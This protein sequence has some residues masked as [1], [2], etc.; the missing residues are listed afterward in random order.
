VEPNSHYRSPTYRELNV[1]DGVGWSNAQPNLRRFDRTSI[2]AESKI[3]P[4][5]N[6]PIGQSK[7]PNEGFM[8]TENGLGIST[9]PQ[10]SV[11]QDGFLK[12][13]VA[14]VG[15]HYT[16]TGQ[17]GIPQTSVGQINVAPTSFDQASPTE[18][19]FSQVNIGQFAVHH[20]GTT[21]VSVTQVAPQN[22]DAVQGSSHQINTT[23]VNILQNSTQTNTSKISFP[24]SV[25]LQQF[26]SSH[27]FSLQNTTI[28]TWTEFL[29]G[30]TPF[31]LN[32]E[33]TDLPT[34]QLAEANITHFDPTGRPTSGTLTHL[35][36][37]RF[38]NDTDANGLGWFIDSK[39]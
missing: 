24:S 32:I 5:I 33:I 4:F 34:G 25:T 15:L 6:T 38:A 8:N 3:R 28:P 1:I 11:D 39:V 7:I 21:E 31:N 17:V 16:R 10:I 12:I 13:G 30:T 23:Q 2:L 35:F 14:E 29:T 36:H 9:T 27:N 18:V 22:S 19:S 37:R 20:E 26:L